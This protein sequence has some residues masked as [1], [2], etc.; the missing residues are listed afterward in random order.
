MDTNTAQSAIKLLQIEA[1]SLNPSALI[2][3]FEMDIGTLAD[4][5]GVIILPS[6]RIF[7]FHNNIKLLN[8]NIVWQ[9]NTYILVPIQ[10][11]GFDITTKGALPTPTLRLTTIE[12]GILSLALLKD[13]IAEMGDLVG[14]NF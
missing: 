14:V 7:R 2:T 4:A 11:S 5:Q 1:S 3:L 8:T 10:A 13:A 9:G 12:Q 6:E